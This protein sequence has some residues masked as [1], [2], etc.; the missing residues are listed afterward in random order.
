LSALLS[1][2]SYIQEIRTAKHG[3]EALSLAEKHQPDVVLLD[4]NM[5]G[6]TGAEVARRLKAANSAARIIFVSADPDAKE[7][8]MAAG[9]EAFFV[10]GV[11]TAGLIQALRV[12]QSPVRKAKRVLKL[13]RKKKKPPKTVPWLTN[14][15]R[16]IIVLLVGGIVLTQ[17]YLLVEGSRDIDDFSP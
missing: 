15:F 11:N 2:E 4:Q 12:A 1:E 5:P 14:I 7:L 6:L 10:K 8:A 13:P 16:V 17:G 3:L 9:A